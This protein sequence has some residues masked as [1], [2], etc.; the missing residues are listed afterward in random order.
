[1][2][3]A[4]TAYSYIRGSISELYSMYSYV[5]IT[6]IYRTIAEAVYSYVYGTLCQIAVAIYRY[7][8]DPLRDIAISLQ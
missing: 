6:Q 7:Q 5:A 2:H 8:Y 1:M 3:H 4:C